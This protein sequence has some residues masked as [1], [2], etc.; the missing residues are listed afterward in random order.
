MSF[1]QEQ[2]TEPGPEA[3]LGQRKRRTSPWLLAL[4]LAL[5]GLLLFL[6]LRGADWS[7]FLA[8]LRQAN[9]AILLLAAG[10]LSVSHLVR[11]VRWNLLLRAE[12]SLPTVSVFWAVMAG[13]LGN[14][15]LPARAGELI[16]SALVARLSRLSVGY[17]LATALTERLL[18]LVA[19]VLLSLVALRWIVGLPPWVAVA[20][21][22][23][24]A[25]AV[26]GVAGLA[27][28]PLFGRQLIAL[29]RRAPLPGGLS[30]RLAELVG[31]F[32]LGMRAIGHPR[33]GAGFAALTTVIWLLDAV[34]AVAVAVALQIGLDIPQALVLLAALGLASAA[35]STP[36]YLGIFQFVAVSILAPFGLAQS[37]ALAFIL[38]F[39]A[40]SYLVVI[41]WGVLGLARIGA[42]PR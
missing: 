18:D 10:L 36:G 23:M 30:S 12:S 7:Q 34:F 40:I 41:V 42:A 21:Q 27:A 37:A 31:Q 20:A 3:A 8:I 24:S 16:R 17:V 13:Y 15:F 35:P 29:L 22:V 2:P 39:Q 4:T 25:V 1:D 11:S 19:L 5:A 32:L 26:V 14:Y 28:L 38:A 9:P 6:A 33:R